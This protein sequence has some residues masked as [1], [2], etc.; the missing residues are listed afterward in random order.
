MAIILDI[1]LFLLVPS[2]G[3]TGP[4][5]QYLF[6]W[7]VLKSPKAW[8]VFFIYHLL[9]CITFFVFLKFKRSEKGIEKV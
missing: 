1:P 2:F 4:D 5:V 7:L 8:I 9:I 3:V 6:V